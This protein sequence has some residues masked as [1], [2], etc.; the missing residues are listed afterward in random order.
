MT[1]TVII[2]IVIKFEINVYKGRKT[3]NKLIKNVTDKLIIT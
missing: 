3:E 2:I 1:K